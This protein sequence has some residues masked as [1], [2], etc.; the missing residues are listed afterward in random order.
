MSKYNHR[1]FFNIQVQDRIREIL[2]IYLSSFLLAAAMEAKLSI[3]T[4]K[5][6]VCTSLDIFFNYF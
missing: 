1:F 2:H 6:A 5:K 3:P 4:D